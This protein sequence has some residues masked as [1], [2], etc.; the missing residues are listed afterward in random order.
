MNEMRRFFK[1]R[2]KFNFF[3][4]TFSDSDRHIGSSAKVWKIDPSA[5]FD[6][7][8]NFQACAV[9]EIRQTRENYP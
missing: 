9:F 5:H 1:N 2:L 3:R 8:P 4:M 7:T 6:T